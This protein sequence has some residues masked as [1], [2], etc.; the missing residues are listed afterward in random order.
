MKIENVT[1]DELIN[2]ISVVNSKRKVL[3]Y[4][5]ISKK[6]GSQLSKL[7]KIIIDNDINISH[8]YE[9]NIGV[10]NSKLEYINKIINNCKSYRDVGIAIG[11]CDELQNMAPRVYILIQ[12]HIKEHDIDISHFNSHT[13][14]S[15]LT[16]IRYD[17]N[18]LFKKDSYA[19]SHTVKKRFIKLNDYKCF[20][21]GISEWMGQSLNLQLDHING[22]K[23]DNTLKNLRLL[24]PNCHSQTNTFAGKNVKR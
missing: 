3:E 7:S 1:L 15:A 2:V 5:G 17:D 6:N 11:L 14:N 9:N 4:L 10:D 19:S 23:T 21:C 8:F 18:E 22:N 24:C 12:N 13:T 20:T 16:T